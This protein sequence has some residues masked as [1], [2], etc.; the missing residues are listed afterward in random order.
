MNYSNVS[1]LRWLDANN[2]LLYC[3]V[4]FES[5]GNNIPFT[6]N[7]N[8]D[9]EYGREIF[10]FALNGDYGII[11]SFERNIEQEW[12]IVRIKRNKLLIDSD[13][14]QL[15]DVQSNMSAPK[16]AEWLTYRQ[17]LRDITDTFSDPADVIWTTAPTN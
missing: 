1:N 12:N 17:Y 3:T 16:K 14:S 11:Q 13:F 5:I 10:Q 4:N 7:A 2:S 6:T 8:Y 9:M 15:P